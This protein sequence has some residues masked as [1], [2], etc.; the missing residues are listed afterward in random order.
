MGAHP[1]SKCWDNTSYSVYTI[2]YKYKW[3]AST[4]YWQVWRGAIPASTVAAAPRVGASYWWAWRK[5]DPVATDAATT[6][7]PTPVTDR[8]DAVP[9]LLPPLPLLLVSAPVTGGLGAR[10]LPL[11]LTLP[12]LSMTNLSYWQAWRGTIPASTVAA[13]PRVSASYWRVWR[14]ADPVATDAAT[15]LATTR[16]SVLG[17]RFCE[18]PQQLLSGLAWCLSRCHC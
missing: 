12:L 13:A 1:I 18:L 16:L 15:P 17:A 3:G 14:K 5:A 4:S 2:Y 10:P 7:W 11:P 6:R 8:P 9:F